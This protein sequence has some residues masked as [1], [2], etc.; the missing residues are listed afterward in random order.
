MRLTG[1]QSTWGTN[2]QVSTKETYFITK[3][4]YFITKE[5]YFI[6]KETYFITKETYFIEPEEI[7]PNEVDMII[8]SVL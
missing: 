7:S 5:T 2:K 4:T 1:H 8:R 3:E 6:T